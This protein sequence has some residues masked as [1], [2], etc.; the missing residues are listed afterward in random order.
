MPQESWP[1]RPP[2]TQFCRPVFMFAMY[3]SE[4][5]PSNRG[6]AA[7]SSASTRP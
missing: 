7:S 1:L 2:F 4:I 6:S 5:V 3:S